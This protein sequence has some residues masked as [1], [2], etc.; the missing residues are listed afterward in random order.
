MQISKSKKISIY[1]FLLILL[2]SINNISLNKIQFEKIEK[3]NVSGLDESDNQKLLKEIKNLNLGNIF[4]INR[5]EINTIINSNSL[6]ETY[7][8]FKKYPSRIDVKLKKTNFLAKINLDGQ[9]FFI[10][11]NGKLTQ[12]FFINEDLPF[13]FGNPNINEFLKFKKIID[14][15]KISYENIKSLFFFRTKRWDIELKNNILIKLSRD[16][17]EK[18]LNNVYLF[19]D[20]ENDSSKKIIDARIQNQIITNE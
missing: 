7:D 19:L 16:N 1:I 15:S 13:I 2:G 12:S 4:F 9:L 3:I 8:I 20:K 11:S 18:D 17:V 6:V 14:N 5:N 10:G